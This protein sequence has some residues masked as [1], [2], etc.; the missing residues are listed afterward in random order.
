MLWR[1]SDWSK[2][3]VLRQVEA[4]RAI[5]HEFETFTAATENMDPANF[6]DLSTKLAGIGIKQG[7]TRALGHLAAIYSDHPDYRE[8]WALLAP[9][10]Q[11]PPEQHEQPGRAQR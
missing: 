3:R 1:F 4:F 7:F 9:P 10:S 8:E 5:L 2:A 6:E 11:R